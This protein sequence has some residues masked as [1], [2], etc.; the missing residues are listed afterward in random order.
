MLGKLVLMMAAKATYMWVM[1]GKAVRAWMTL[2]EE[3]SS[4]DNV[5]LKQLPDYQCYVGTVHLA[6]VMII[7]SFFLLFSSVMIYKIFQCYSC[8]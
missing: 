7:K 3:T 1:V 6:I 5:L 8:L 2:T 4:P